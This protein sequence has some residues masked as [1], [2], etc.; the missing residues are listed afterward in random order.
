MNIPCPSC[1]TICPIHNSSYC[2]SAHCYSCQLN[3]FY[4]T[5]FSPLEFRY[6]TASIEIRILPKL[7]LTLI[8]FY[9][10]Y[11]PTKTFELKALQPIPL[12]LLKDKIDKLIAFL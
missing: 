5:D 12:H 7:N 2:H 11:K 3:H 1:Q 6:S 9:D 4:D 10:K 8:Y